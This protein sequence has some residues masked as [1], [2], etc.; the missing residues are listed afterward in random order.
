M[1]NVLIIST[2]GGFITS[3]QLNNIKLWQQHNCN[4]FCLS[5]FSD[6]NYNKSPEKLL[7]LNISI[8]N[9][10]FSRKLKDIKFLKTINFIKKIII[11]KKIDIIECHNPIISTLARIAAKKTNVKIVIYTVHGFFFYKNSSLKSKLIFK[12]IEKE[13]AKK[14]DIIIT[15]NLEDYETAKKMKVRKKVFYV[16]GVGVDVDSIDKIKVNKEDLK[17]E[18]KIPKN[19]FVIT[20]VGEC[21]NRKNHLTVIK[22]LKNCKNQNI[23]YILIGDGVLFTSLIE[24]AKK[25]GVYD[26]IRFL[27]YRKDANKFLKITDLYVFPSYQEGLSVALMEAMCAKLPVVCSRI[28]GNVD[29]IIE[30]KGGLYFEPNDFLTLSNEIDKISNDYSMQKEFGEYNR[31][32]V[33]EFSIGNVESEMNKIY[34]YAIEFCDERS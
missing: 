24:Q 25:L 15:T 29:C 8:I 28:R 4:V 23:Y 17:K 11:E 31:K 16:H 19:A 32:K 5:N 13:M 7:N 26:R 33:N 12:N 30:N 9:A 22:A 3:F 14:T 20:S 1:K 34:D 10:D 2:Y 18:Y 27:G 6:T 21:I